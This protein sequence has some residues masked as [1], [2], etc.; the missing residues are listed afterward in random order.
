MEVRHANI[1][2]IKI[3]RTYISVFITFSNPVRNPMMGAK[4]K[5]LEI[6]Y[7]GLLENTSSRPRTAKN[8][9]QKRVN[10]DRHFS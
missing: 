3:G 1:E 8:A 6:C 10:N 7:S 2:Q 5:H 4:D 9:P